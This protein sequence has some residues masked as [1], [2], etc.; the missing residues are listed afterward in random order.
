VIATAAYTG[1]RIREVLA[2]RWR[3]VDHGRGLIHLRGQLNP[4]GTAIVSMKTEESK[5]INALVPKLE[6]YVGREARMRARWSGDDDYVFAAGYQR[7]KDYRNVR[8]ALTIASKH[9]GLARVRAHDLRHSFTS[10]LIPHT[11]LMTVSRAVGHKNIAITAKVYAHALGTPEEQAQRA[12]Q[13]AAAAG[14]GY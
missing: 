6:P 9:A 1:A 11:D 13:A 5:R 7:P 14:L 10:N 4:G 12:A 3:D 2:L 8:R